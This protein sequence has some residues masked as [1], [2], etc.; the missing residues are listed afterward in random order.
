MEYRGR[1]ALSGASLC[2]AEG[3]VHALVGPSG[4][5][6]TTLINLLA[7]FLAP[8]RGVIRFRG[9][10]IA[11]RAPEEIG[12]LGIAR[13]FRM[14]G[15]FDQLSA[16]DHVEL[17]LAPATGLRHRF[18]RS[19]RQAQ[20]KLGPRALD[21]LDQV[22]LAGRSGAA[23]GSL[24]DS[25]KCA[26]EVALALTLDPRVLLLDEL[27]AGLAP[28]DVDRTIALVRRVAAGRTVVLVDHDMHVVRALADTVT[29]LQSGRVLAE[30]T[31]DQVRRDERVVAAYLGQ[32][33]QP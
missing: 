17:A 8:T 33:A 10:D 6:K 11:G 2:V 31:Y 15:L 9:E 16:L 13:S 1:P 22:E 3:T 26:L 14:T 29:V 4:A 23:A 21:L 5:G 24:A 18:W 32:A 27:T 7:G 20:H 19:N 25:E 30:G 12:H 28:E